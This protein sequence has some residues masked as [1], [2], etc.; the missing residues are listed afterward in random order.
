MRFLAVLWTVLVFLV[1]QTENTPTTLYLT[2]S[3]VQLPL[4]TAL[5][6]FAVY[7]CSKVYLC[8]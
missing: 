4:I 1:V 6:H 3:S 5:K 8:V 7:K 2:S